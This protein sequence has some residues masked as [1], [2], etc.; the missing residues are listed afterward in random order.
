MQ[1]TTAK[2]AKELGIEVM[3]PYLDARVVAF[4]KTLS[5]SDMVG[6]RTPVPRDESKESRSRPEPP[7]RDCNSGYFDSHW[8]DKE[9]AEQQHVVFQGHGVYIRDREHLYFFRAFLSAFDGDLAKVPR[10]KFN[11]AKQKVDAHGEEEA[12]DSANGFLLRVRV[13]VIPSE[14]GHLRDLR[15]TYQRLTRL[16]HPSS[17]QA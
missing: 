16:C 10:R 11:E 13:R 9:F 5:K 17:R 8:T 14:A 4:S 3:S 2:L 7:R 1:F 6:D 12:A 15:L